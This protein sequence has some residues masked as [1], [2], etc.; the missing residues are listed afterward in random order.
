MDNRFALAQSILK[1][2]LKQSLGPDDPGRRKPALSMKLVLPLAAGLFIPAIL[3]GLFSSM[4][5]VRALATVLEILVS[6]A[7]LARPFWGLLVLI[8]LV[9]IRPEDSIAALENMQLVLTVSLVLIASTAMNLMIRRERILWTPQCTMLAGFG[10]MAVIST[11]SGGEPIQAATDV[12]KLIILAVATINIVRTPQQYFTL[13]AAIVLLSAYVALQAMLEGHY[14]DENGVL[15]LTGTGIFDNPNDL[16]M[17]LVPGIVLALMQFERSRPAIRVGLIAAALVMVRALLLTNSRG[18]LLALMVSAGIYF[19]TVVSLSDRNRKSGNSKR[20]YGP[21]VGVAVLLLL[22]F[23]AAGRARNFDSKEA[24]ANSRVE[25]WAN[26]ISQLVA[27]PATGVGYLQFP[28]VN[29][30]MNAHSIFVICFAELGFIGYFCWIGAL[31]YCFKGRRPHAEE[32]ELP[33][34]KVAAREL[35]G[36][37]L[38][39]AGYLVAGAFGNFTY[40]PITYILMMTPAACRLTL[41]PG[42]GAAGNGMSDNGM[43]DN[44]MSDNGMSDNGIEANPGTRERVRDAIGILL[45]SVGSILLMKLLIPILH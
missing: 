4:D 25:F 18:G 2:T 23:L 17:A 10:L 27:H 9:Y 13:T 20:G 44:G 24:S 45:V 8:G 35:F 37:R 12:G 34:Q 3:T 22:F 43:S 30:G 40:I 14:I 31:Y 7:I 6:L 26:G 38:A 39:L 21:L 19:S 29:E 33:G 42:N 11:L 36:T 28:T 15:R 1:P 32:G 16:C 41:A 5:S